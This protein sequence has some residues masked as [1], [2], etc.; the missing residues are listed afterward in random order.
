V[1]RLQGDCKATVQRWQGD[2]KATVQ[3]YKSNRRAISY[4]LQ[5]GGRVIDCTTIQE[6][7]CGN[8]EAIE[9]RFHTDCRAITERL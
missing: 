4:L 5:G 2:C 6:G 8:I 1:Q 3:R 9:A 7:L